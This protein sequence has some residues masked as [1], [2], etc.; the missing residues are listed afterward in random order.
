MKNNQIYDTPLDEW[1]KQPLR[2]CYQQGKKQHIRRKIN[3]YWT[4][5]ATYETTDIINE[6][7]SDESKI[8]KL[9]L[10]VLKVTQITFDP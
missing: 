8:I 5:Y 1:S 9:I 7:I 10:D 4:S 3:R 2:Q 6:K